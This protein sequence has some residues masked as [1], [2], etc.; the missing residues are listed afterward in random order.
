MGMETTAHPPVLFYAFPVEALS[1]SPV[2][3][4]AL[5]YIDNNQK[6]RSTTYTNTPWTKQQQQQQQQ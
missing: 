1:R 6:N 5:A 3:T 2:D 4:T